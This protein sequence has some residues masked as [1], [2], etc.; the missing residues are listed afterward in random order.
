MKVIQMI[1]PVLF[2]VLI[3][4]I[5]CGQQPKSDKTPSEKTT[6]DKSEVQASVKEIINN[7][8]TPFELSSKLE[9]IGVGYIDGAVNSVDKIDKYFTEKNKALNLG[10]YGADLAY[11]STYSKKQEM[12]MYADAV[13]KLINQL[14]IK[15]D[16]AKL[17]SDETKA[18]FDNKDSLV[19]IVTNTFLEVYNFLNENSDPSLAAL[20]ATGIWTESMY[21]AMQISEESYNN[22]DFVKIIFDQKISLEKIIELLNLFPEDEMIVAKKTVLQELHNQYGSSDG[23]LT[24]EQLSAIAQI[25]NSIRSE[26]IE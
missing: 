19:N 2:F 26:I 4:V 15:V 17:S 18:K 24:V 22:T 10:V 1:K 21:M 8:P 9:E 11:V 20:V 3:L 25:I 16:Y 12:N 13:R 6:I 14:N 23:S 7:I 5:G